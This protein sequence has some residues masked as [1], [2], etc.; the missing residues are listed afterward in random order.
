MWHELGK[1]CYEE[2]S[3]TD[4]LAAFEKAVALEPDNEQFKRDRDAA[5]G[6]I[7][8]PTPKFNGIG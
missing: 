2:G 5:R 1:V 4:A 7:K 8:N 6:M 3:Y